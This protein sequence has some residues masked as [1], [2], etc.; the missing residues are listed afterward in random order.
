MEDV[1]A[2]V[3]FG[4]DQQ[5]LRAMDAL[6]GI[7]TTAVE[8]LFVI[9]GPSGVGKSSFLRAGLLPRLRRDRGNFQV[10]DIVRPERAPLTGDHGLARCISELRSRARLTGPTLGD[11]KD[12]CLSGDAAQLTEW[13]RE[14]QR[15]LA[16]ED[17]PPTLVVLP[18]VSLPRHHDC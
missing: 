5:I 6:R 7:R 13:L 9:L 15:S 2:A 8:G 1:D 3:F 4:R 12:A 18:G 16:I 11:I 10:C 14:A 17:V